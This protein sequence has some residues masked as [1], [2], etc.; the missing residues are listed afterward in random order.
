[1]PRLPR[2]IVAAMAAVVLVAGLLAWVLLRDDSDTEPAA[3]APATISAPS[4]TPVTA[5]APPQNRCTRAADLPFTPERISIPGV[6]DRAAVIPV[7]RDSRGVTGVLPYS[8]KVDFAW[9]E[10]GIRPGTPRGNVLLNTHTWADGSALGNLMLVGLEEGDRIV[11]EGL[12][13]ARLCYRVTRRIEV[14]AADGYEP[15]YEDDGPPRLAFIVCS[16]TRSSGG[17]WSHRT[18]W[19]ARLVR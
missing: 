18:I 8:N 10:D 2:T 7:P 4:T 15:Y 17:E 3:D 12:A 13:K 19:F 1:M 5:P 14:D 6:A 16:G 11:V 9:D